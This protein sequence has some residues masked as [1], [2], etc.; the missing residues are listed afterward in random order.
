MLRFLAAV[1]PALRDVSRSSRLHPHCRRVGTR[2]LIGPTVKLPILSGGHK[3][4]GGCRSFDVTAYRDKNPDLSASF[5][6]GRKAGFIHY[7]E[8]GQYEN[9]KTR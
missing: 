1:F 9:R 6:D 2:R 8:S 5:G 4:R 7:V 3:G